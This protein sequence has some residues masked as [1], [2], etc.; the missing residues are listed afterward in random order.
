MLKRPARYEKCVLLAEH[1]EP[2]TYKEDIASKESSEWL[3]AMKEEMDSL[4]EANNTWELVNPPQDRKATRSRWVCKIKKNADGTAQ[5]FK[6][7]LV[8][9]GYSQKVGVDFNETFS[10]VVRWDT[11]RTVLSVARGGARGGTGVP[12][13]PAGDTVPL[14]GENFCKLLGYSTSW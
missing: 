9:K 13:P 6:A 10:L 4:L 8:A 5:R 7:R 2:D 12:G 1:A 11:I 14:I 3:A